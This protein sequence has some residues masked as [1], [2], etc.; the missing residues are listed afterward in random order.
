M[1]IHSF[2]DFYN[3]NYFSDFDKYQHDWISAKNALLQ[4]KGHW[5][6]RGMR[7]SQWHLETSIER[8]T[9]SGV[10]FDD[11]EKMLH[12][13]FTRNLHNYLSAEK[14]PDC[15]YLEE[16]ALMQHHGAPTRLLDWTLSPYIAAFFAMEDPTTSSQGRAIWAIDLEWCMLKGVEQIKRTSPDPQYKNTSSPK[17]PISIWRNTEAFMDIFVRDRLKLIFPMEPYRINERMRI[18][19]GLFL[20]PGNIRIGFMNNLFA[21]YDENEEKQ[22]GPK[23]L[24]IIVSENSRKDSLNDLN[25]MNINRET[26]F[27]GIDGFAQSLKLYTVLNS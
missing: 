6:F 15:H 2:S 12:E 10:F 4:L 8:F 21:Y 24:K 18:Q 25:S 23:V 5:A 13:K 14:L 16:L 11:A 9:A 22:T 20:C 1:P 26:L 19:K 7:D 17:Q 3:S 27:P